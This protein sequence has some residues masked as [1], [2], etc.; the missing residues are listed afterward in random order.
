MRVLRS[1]RAAHAGKQPVA[2]H[3]KEDARLTVLKHQEHCRHGDHRAQRDQPANAGVSRQFER[4]GQRVGDRELIVPNHA[5]QH[6]AHDDIDD[7]AHRQAAENPDRQVTLR[8]TC[9]FGSCRH[10]VEADVRKEHD[11]RALVD[12]GEAVRRKR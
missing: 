8:I 12:A 7:R 4:A 11:C 6:G 3:R 10:R 5:R 9:F 1:T 2:R